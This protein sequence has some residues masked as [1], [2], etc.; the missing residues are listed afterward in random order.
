MADDTRLPIGTQDGDTYRSDDI[1]GVKTQLVKLEIGADGVSDGMVSAANPLPVT[2]ASLPLPAGAATAAKQPALGTAGTASADVITVQGVASMTALKVDGSGVTQPVSIETGSN[3]IGKVSIVDAAGDSAMD[4]A[5]DALRVNVVASSV[6]GGD[7][8]ILD[9]VSSAIKATVLDYANSNPLAVRLTDTGGDY[10]SVGGGTQYTE[11]VAAAADPTGTM[12]MAVRADSLAAVTSTDGDNIAARATNKGELYVKH[13]DAV[14]VTGVSTL[15]EQQTQTTALQLIDDTVHAANAAL[16]KVNAIGAQMDDAATAVATEGNVSAL[17]VDTNRALHVQLRSGAAE[18]GTSGAPLRTD[19]TGTTTQPVS[20]A[21]TVNVQDNASLVDNAGFTDGTT[22]V[23]MDG[24]IFDEVAGTALTENDAAAARV[25]S[26]RAQVLVLEDATTRGQRAAIGS[27]G[28]LEVQGD[29]A[30]DSPASGNPV[31]MGGRAQSV[32]IPT[33]VSEGDAVRIWCGSTGAQVIHIAGGVSGEWVGGDA[34]NGLD[35]DVTRLPALPAGTNNIGD[36]D[37]LTVPAPLNVVGNGAAATALRVTM[38]NDSTG[39]VAATVS[40]AT[41]S[42]LNAEVQ[43]DAAS[44][45]PVSGNPVLQGGRAS[46][47]APGDV[48]A[49]GDA[50]SAWYLRNGAAATALTAGG[51]LIGGDA[52]N[53]LDVDVIRLGGSDVAHDAADAGNPHK[54]GAKAANA[55]PTAVANADRVNAI[56]DLF[57]RLMTTH[58]DPAQQKHANKTY[59]TQQTG[60]D[61]ITPTSGKKLAITS[62][63][64]GSYGT[65]AGR[66]ILWFGDNADTTFTQD[67][68]QVLVAASFAPSATVKPGLVFHPSVPV[69]CTTADREL[70]IT[71]DAALSADITIEYYE[72]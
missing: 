11:D 55:L 43:G 51:A 6:G 8:A 20:I 9:G 46:A 10:V 3:V 61:V 59:T 40:Q 68:D 64:I 65:T 14:T 5:N 7:G 17:R 4:G 22:R 70:H 19:P 69:F 44:D 18:V 21:A 48:S 60:T 37:V 58:I 66:L 42:N 63:V 24:F 28:A 15:A 27:G 57:G 16:G 32:G 50:V 39:I 34:A 56:A 35:V 45:A 31:L 53:G 54:I 13:A 12:A 49:D 67:T 2:A 25:D 30:H 23:V 72:F 41:A 33:L 62:V 52:T 1:G 29:I 71:T 26:K 38:A 47:A 36:V